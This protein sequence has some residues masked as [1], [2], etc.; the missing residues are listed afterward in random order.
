MQDSTPPPAAR[1][2]P[3]QSAAPARINPAHR[4]RVLACLPLLLLLGTQ[5]TQP[6]T[7]ATAKSDWRFSLL[8]RQVVDTIAENFY[9]A[10]VAKQWAERHRDYAGA[11]HDRETF[12]RLTRAALAEL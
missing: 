11:G 8:G 12:V 10:N 5:G 6:A 4:R 2:T 1:S 7:T 9:D 3:G